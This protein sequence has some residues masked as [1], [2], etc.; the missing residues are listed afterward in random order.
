[1]LLYARR[2]P[3]KDPKR[4]SRTEHDTECV[5]EAAK[6]RQRKKREVRSNDAAAINPELDDGATLVPFIRG[7]AS[8]ATTPESLG[9][10]LGKATSPPALVSSVSALHL[11]PQTQLVE[12]MDPFEL[13]LLEHYLEHTSRDLADNDGDKYAPQNSIPI[14]ACKS[15]PLMWSVLALSAVCRCRDILVQNPDGKPLSPFELIRVRELL[16]LANDYHL[17]SLG[18]TRKVLQQSAYYNHTL[19]SAAMMAMYGSG[20]HVVSIWLAKIQ[21]LSTAGDMVLSHS[22]WISLWRALGVASRIND[23]AP[24]EYLVALRINHE[25]AIPEHPLARVLADTVSP[26]MVRLRQNAIHRPVEPSCLDALGVLEA[27]ATKTCNLIQG[28]S[29]SQ[30]GGLSFKVVKHPHLSLQLPHHFIVAFTHQAPALYFSLVD[31]AMSSLLTEP[32]DPLPMSVSVPDQPA[33]KVYDPG[34]GD[35]RLKGGLLD[36]SH[37]LALDIFCH[38]LVFVMLLDNVW[39]IDGIG[40]WELGHIVAVRGT[41]QWSCPDDWW[42]GRM[43]EVRRFQLSHRQ[44]SSTDHHNESGFSTAALGAQLASMWAATRFPHA[45]ENGSGKVS[46]EK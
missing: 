4:R 24:P 3:P 38:W 36:P 32:A 20:T 8:A 46:A 7:E 27:V 29:Q 37:R 25:T 30:N 6:P 15:K 41:G 11:L 13:D 2:P 14:L 26:A 22:Q 43:W 16:A 21:A 35:I 23:A 42:P 10:S 17:K 34:Q 12:T 28:H 1:M 9:Q 31:E 45:Q 18:E 5:Y 44:S 39:W 33:P 40:A 19:T